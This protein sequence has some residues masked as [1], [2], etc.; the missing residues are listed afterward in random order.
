[1]SLKLLKNCCAELMSISPTYVPSASKKSD[2]LSQGILGISSSCI[3]PTII[4]PEEMYGFET[5][6]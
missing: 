6:I 4:V 1:M 2:A 3:V 5:D